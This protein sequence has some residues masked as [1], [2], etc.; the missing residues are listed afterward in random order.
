MRF[1]GEKH[2]ERPPVGGVVLTKITLEDKYAKSLRPARL[3][4]DI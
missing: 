4:H 2:A 3:T 1:A